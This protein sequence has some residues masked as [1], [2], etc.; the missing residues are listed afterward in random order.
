[1]YVL[2]AGG[3]YSFLLATALSLM[4]THIIIHFHRKI[5][6]KGDLKFDEIKE[7]LSEK[8]K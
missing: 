8:I 2:P 3:F 5:N 1:M 4:I 6:E 7:K